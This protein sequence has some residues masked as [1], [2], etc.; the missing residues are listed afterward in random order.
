MTESIRFLSMYSDDFIDNIYIS[1]NF[2]RISWTPAKKNEKKTPSLLL[3]DRTVTHY[4][5]LLPS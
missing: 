4:D 5:R 2:R 3:A 1:E